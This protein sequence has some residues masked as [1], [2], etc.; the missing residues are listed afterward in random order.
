M[1]PSNRLIFDLKRYT[2]INNTPGFK[3]NEISYPHT[4]RLNDKLGRIYSYKLYAAL[5]HDGIIDQRHYYS[6]VSDPE[7]QN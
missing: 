7:K 5:H 3:R 4:L 6:K 1:E 2:F